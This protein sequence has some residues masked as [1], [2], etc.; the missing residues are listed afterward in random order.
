[1]TADA[2]EDFAGMFGELSRRD[3]GIGAWLVKPRKDA[4]TYS[5]I[6]GPA[7]FHTDSQYHH[8][9]E[10]LFVLACD[11]PAEEGGDNLLIS[12]DD[13]REI[14]QISLGDDAVARMQQ[15]VWRWAVPEVFQSATV[16]AVSP[17]S[18]IFREDGPFAGASTILSAKP[19][20]TNSWP[21]YLSRLSR[22]HPGLRMSVCSQGMS[23]SATTGIPSMP[24]PISATT[25]ACSSGPGWCNAQRD[26]RLGPQPSNAIPS[27]QTN[28]STNRTSR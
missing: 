12:V 10:R 18:A 13:A 23:W 25:I 1:M 7:G 16:P 17:P 15:S 11:T 4:G 20:P 19:M 21:R 22:A 6:K 14:A 5:E 27:Q 8:Q 3:G 28:G 2:V 26:R 9:P 24:A